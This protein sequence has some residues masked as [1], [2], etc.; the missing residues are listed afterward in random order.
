MIL[1][2]PPGDVI[3]DDADDGVEVFA[4]AE[5]AKRW[6]PRGAVVEAVLEEGA[7]VGEPNFAVDADLSNAAS[8]HTSPVLGVGVVTGD[9]D[10]EG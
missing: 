10:V 5:G 6:S 1:T 8:P 9:S 2:L 7:D 3:K 4:F